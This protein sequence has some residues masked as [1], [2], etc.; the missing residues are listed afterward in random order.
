MR[1]KIRLREAILYLVSSIL[2]LL[3]F[4]KVPQSRE[5]DLTQGFID[6]DGHRIAQV[7]APGIGSHGDADTIF[8]MLRQ[9]ILRQSFGFL[10]EEEVAA[11]LEVCFRIAPGCFGGQTPHLTYIIFGEEIGKV[12][13][14]INLYH[15]PVIQS[16]PTNRLFGDVKAKRTDQ[17]EPA[18]GGCTG[19]GDV[20]AV[21]GNLRFHQYN[22]E[23]FHHL[24]KSTA[25]RFPKSARVLLYAKWTVKSILKM[26]FS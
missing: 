2:Y 23:Q 12:F 11:I 4:A 13:V 25:D 19:A 24:I 6:G 7:K 21:L 17:M 10:A 18:A 14:V 8:V 9:K 20:A 22:V 15:V 3:H 26:L 16:C 1:Y 5:I